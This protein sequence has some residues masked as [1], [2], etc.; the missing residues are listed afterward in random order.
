MIFT[1]VLTVFQA[2]RTPQILRQST[3][4]LSAFGAILSAVGILIYGNALSVTANIISLLT[5]SFAAFSARNSLVI[6]LFHSVYSIGGALVFMMLDAFD[7][8]VEEKKKDKSGFTFMKLLFYVIL[9]LGAL[10]IF[11]GLYRSSNSVFEALTD[12]IDLSFISI[13]WFF[14]LITGLLMMYGYFRHKIIPPFQRFDEGAPMEMKPR[15][16]P[17][18]FDSLLSENV[19]NRSGIV[20]FALLN[21]LILVLNVGDI[22][23]M[24]GGSVLPEGVSLS[25]SVHQGV[26]ALIVSIVFAVLIILFYFRGRLNF[27]QGNNAIKGL[28]ILWIGQNLLMVAS[29]AYRNFD[30]IDAHGLTL[31]RIG[32]YVYLLLT[33][34]GLV[35]TAVKLLKIRTN[36]YLVKAVSWSFYIIL[37]ISPLVNW[38]RLVLESQ[39]KVAQ[40][41]NKALDVHYLIDVSSYCY[42]TVYEYLQNHD[43]ENLRWDLER[44]IGRFLTKS[45]NDDW[46][47]YNQRN[48]ELKEFIDSNYDEEQQEELKNAG[49]RFWF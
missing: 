7:R 42:P 8:P 6:G 49:N 13:E 3:W 18:M 36:W 37:A 47:S 15:E 33:I 28:A 30:Y 25:D 5:M 46:R 23:F 35:F 22:L 26:G 32:V 12:N 27:F 21:L 16:R 31:K 17:T 14:F 41:D 2:I 1:G 24:S 20:M 19:E 45:E 29:T 4:L 9:P 40:Q 44:K 43:D 10:L 38:D 34:I 39:V 48:R 11:F